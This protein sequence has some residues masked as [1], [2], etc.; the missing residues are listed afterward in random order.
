MTPVIAI[1][2]GCASDDQRHA[3]Y[4]ETLYQQ[5]TIATSGSTARED[6]GRAQV[7]T[8]V[9]TGAAQTGTYTSSPST[10]YSSDVFSTRSEDNNLVSTVRQAI[11]ND[12][13]L[14][15][16]AS[17]IQI[18]A[19]SGTVT[20]F[21]K[22][23]SEDQKQS[24]ESLVRQTSGVT[25][26]NNQLQVAGD[27]AAATTINVD[28]RLS[29]T[30]TEHGAE[31]AAE[32]AMRQ[33]AGG[34]V[35]SGEI[36][37][38]SGEESNALTA[39]SRTNEAANVYGTT[40]T[41]SNLVDSTTEQLEQT[42]AAGMEGRV[43]SSTNALGHTGTNELLSATS[44]SGETSQSSAGQTGGITVNVQGTTQADRT[45]AQQISQELRSDASLASAIS[46]VSISVNEGRVTLRGAVKN[47]VQKKEI[48]SAIQRATGVSS[49][50]NQLRVGT[51]PDSVPHTP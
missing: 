34:A 39:T 6:V 11:T 19:S 37:S 51:S 44:T 32:A 16:V 10:F 30:S 45:L 1:A 24:V 48:E 26:V 21:G 36:Q 22:V 31:Q 50:D 42:S 41:S 27:T 4:D 8:D 15:G 47:D 13:A 33:A 2:A 12:A 23:G 3:R 43:Y 29:A 35:A 28:E 14:A 46:Q 49:I 18:G 20:L 38:Q 5:P 17:S 40:T 7:Q 9:Q 25:T